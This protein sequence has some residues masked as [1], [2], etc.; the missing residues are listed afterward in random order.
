MKKQMTM[1]KI[2]FPAMIAALYF[3]LSMPF[4]SLSF[5]PVQCRLSEALTILPIFN[6]WAICGLVIG[7]AVTNLAGVA[8][9]T[10]ILGAAD[11]LI[12]TAATLIAA[13]LT[14]WLR[15]LR[16]KKWPVWATLPPVL[17]NAAVVGGE[18][19]FAWGALPVWAYVAQ[20][21]AGQVIACVLLGLPLALALEKT[22]FAEKL[23]AI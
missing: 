16:I 6:P 22:G 7:C 4:L 21:G 8:L 13:V 20:V 1:K 11:I 19:H 5:G 10:N 17:I 14:Y 12:G 3:V 15:N 2:A 18:M 9:G 23:R